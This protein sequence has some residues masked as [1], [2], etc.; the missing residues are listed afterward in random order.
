[1]KLFTRWILLGIVSL[2]LLACDKDSEEFDQS[3]PPPHN[4][5][6]FQDVNWGD[7]NCQ[8]QTN[9]QSVILNFE[10]DAIK[11]FLRQEFNSPMSS[12][13][14]GRTLW[15]KWTRFTRTSN[16]SDE[17]FDQIL[18]FVIEVLD[19]ETCMIDQNLDEKLKTYLK[20]IEDYKNENL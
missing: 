19:L 4:Q 6:E 2:N 8:L 14:C 12:F 16:W 15:K 9:C 3:V 18:N 7:L 10:Y 1:M 17:E 11:S 5:E 13:S 20:N